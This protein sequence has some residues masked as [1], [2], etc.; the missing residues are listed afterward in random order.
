MYIISD[1]LIGLPTELEWPVGLS[2]PRNSFQPF[3]PQAIELLVPE[4]EHLAKDL[5]EVMSQCY[6]ESLELLDQSCLVY[7]SI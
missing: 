1:R 6:D 5:L 2:V 3:Q 7:T 4:I